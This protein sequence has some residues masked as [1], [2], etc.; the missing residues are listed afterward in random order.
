MLRDLHKSWNKRSSRQALSSCP[1][2]HFLQ[3]IHLS[4][5][6]GMDCQC[7]GRE[8][9]DHGTFLLRQRLLKAMLEIAAQDA[10]HIHIWRCCS[11][12]HQPLRVT[13]A[14]HPED[15]TPHGALAFWDDV[16]SVGV[17]LKP[18]Q[19]KQVQHLLIRGR[20]G[21]RTVGRTWESR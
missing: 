18:P 4:V 10:R 21:G 8:C 15:I 3:G 17:L 2:M 7:C 6:H 1:N 9:M 11:V 12:E 14:Y 13:R 20:A 16:D 5:F 19:A